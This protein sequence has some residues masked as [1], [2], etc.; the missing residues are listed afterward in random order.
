MQSLGISE[1]EVSD[2]Y[3]FSSSL[4]R[5][6]DK[7]PLKT[8][9]RHEILTVLNYRRICQNQRQRKECMRR[10]GLPFE[11]PVSFAFEVNLKVLA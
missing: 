1:G 4:Q 6:A 7:S 2:A 10:H 5:N 11:R 9:T 3:G 8:D